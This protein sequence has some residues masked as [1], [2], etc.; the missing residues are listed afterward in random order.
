MENKKISK[1][2]WINFLKLYSSSGL[3]NC[4]NK[5]IMLGAVFVVLI[6]NA[7]TVCWLCLK[8]QPQDAEALQDLIQTLLF[9]VLSSGAVGLGLSKQSG[10]KADEENDTNQTNTTENK[11]EK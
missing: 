7:A 5:K 1:E 3:A 6:I 2:F 9:L 10:T 8:S 11:G 4:L